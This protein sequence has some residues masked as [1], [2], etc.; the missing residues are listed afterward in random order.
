MSPAVPELSLVVISYEMR[1]ELPRTLYSLSPEYQQGISARDYEVIVVDNGSREPP[2]TEQFAELGM[3]LEI[4][5]QADP[6]PSP[7]RAINQG[8][9]RA[10]A[11]FIGVMIDGARMASPGLLNAC[12]L[13]GRM[14]PRAVVTT[15]SFHLG[16]GLQWLSMQHGYDAAWEDRLLEGIDWRSDGYRLFDIAPTCENAHKGWFGPLNESNALFL[17]RDLWDELG[18]YDPGFESPGGGAVNPD[19]LWRALALPGTRQVVVLG[20]GTFHQIHGGVATNSADGAADF[21]KRGAREYFRL[22]RKAPTPIDTERTYF[23]PVSRAAAKTYHRRL[24]A[25][26][27]VAPISFRGAAGPSA[28]GARYLELLKKVLLNEVGLDVEVALTALRAMKEV[29]ESFWRET[30][31]DVPGR[32]A[33]ALV[34]ARHRRALGFDTDQPGQGCPLGYTMIGRK[35]LDHLQWCV[36]T[37]L[38]EGIAGDFMECGVW[39]GGACM[40]MKAILD[41]RGCEDRRV[42][43]ADSFAGLPPPQGPEDQGVDLS[44]EGF[45][46]LAVS[47]GRVA[48]AFGDLGLLDERVRFVPGWF[49]DSLPGCEVEA[50]AVL[51]LDGDLYSSTRDA[52]AALY[53]RVSP[54]GFVIIDDYG[55]L[56]Q[57]AAAVEDFRAEHGITAPIT[58]IDWCGAFWRKP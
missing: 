48:Q 57:C 44:R 30:L 55:A 9:S 53:H 42:W 1:R 47:Q 29:P 49:A 35:R 38:D 40:L 5:R 25:G 41:L 52:L 13:A 50:L 33:D 34:A 45:P 39:R 14:D 7:V 21:I 28:I 46:M 3:D 4:Y 2:T 58:M 16:P 56:D 24:A 15:L 18:G 37:A 22:R 11:P 19:T 17:H 23:G 43:L 36:T 31:Y 27:A 32:L 51:R 10:R 20:E 8:L 26:A 12:R 54:G 6:G